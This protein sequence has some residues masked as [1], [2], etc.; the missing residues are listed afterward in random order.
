MGMRRLPV[1]VVCRDDSGVTGLL[2]ICPAFRTR[3]CANFRRPESG[4]VKQATSSSPHW[5]SIAK[6]ST[7]ASPMTLKRLMKEAQAEQHPSKTKRD[8]N[9]VQLQPR[10]V[11]GEP[12]LFEW[13]ATL[14]GPPTGAY[15]G[16]S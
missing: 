2:D 9:I 1:K 5:A 8:E 6:M 15:E 12:N 3:P 10:N 13:E 14:R 7:D 11:Q 16:M 4:G